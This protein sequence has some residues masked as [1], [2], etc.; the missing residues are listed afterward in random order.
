V[1]T[2][3]PSLGL[4]GALTQEN[5]EACKEH[6][7]IHLRILRELRGLFAAALPSCL[8]WGLLPGQS[9]ARYIK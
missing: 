2:V 4:A 8:T 3:N 5:H 7:E 1:S 6:K 9:H